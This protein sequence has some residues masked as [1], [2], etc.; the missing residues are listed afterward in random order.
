MTL[1][2]LIS[3]SLFSMT[4]SI[5]VFGGGGAGGGPSWA[6]CGRN[7]N[8]TPKILTY[9]GSNK[10]F[11]LSNSYETRLSPRPTTCSQSNWLEKARRPMMCVTVRASHPSD[12]M[13]TE[14]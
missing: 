6:S 13:P 5:L 11:F 9:S 7:V 14:I 8:G 2:Q 10:F 4:D 12:S 3:K 1:G